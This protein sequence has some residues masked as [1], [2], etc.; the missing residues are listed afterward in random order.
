MKVINFITCPKCN[1][2]EYEINDYE[3]D[4]DQCESEKWWECT[5]AKCNTKFSICINW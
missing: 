3:E 2:E 5:C 1:S 4:F